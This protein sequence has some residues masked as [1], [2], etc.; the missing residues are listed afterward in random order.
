[1]A[2]ADIDP[3]YNPDLRREFVDLRDGV[4]DR[5]RQAA[6]LLGI[7]ILDHVVIGDG[8]YVSFAEQQLL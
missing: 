2:D 3:D 4:Y 5:L 8:R 1:M 7:R 6:D